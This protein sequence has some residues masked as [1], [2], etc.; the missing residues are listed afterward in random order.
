MMAKASES[1]PISPST[2]QRP[3]SLFLAVLIIS[4]AKNAKQRQT[5]RNTW[6]KFGGQRSLTHRF[7]I[8]TFELSEEQLTAL[9]SEARTHNDLLLLS[10]I[11]DNYSGLTSKL[12]NSLKWFASN[13]R[14]EYLLKLDDDSFARIDKIYDEL[15]AMNKVRTNL[16][17]GYFDGRASVKRRGHWKEENWFLCDRYL[18]YALGG[19]YLLSRYLVDFVA[20]NAH[21]LQ[22]YNNEDVSLGVWLSPLKIDRIHEPRFDTEYES[23][24]CL[25]EFLIT[26][27]QSMDLMFEKYNNI[28]KFGKMCAKEIIHRNLYLYNWKVQPSQCCI[29]NISSISS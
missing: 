26:H 16:Y 9:D 12:L 18:P 14:F 1:S 7:V 17:W 28:L 4:C 24:G 5:I 11:D 6:L 29:R 2:E 8:G 22:L 13:E 3:P 15:K 25:N 27:K 10:N 21:L 20:K 23:R 19:G